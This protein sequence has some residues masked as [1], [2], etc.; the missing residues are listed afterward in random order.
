MGLIQNMPEDIPTTNAL[1]YIEDPEELNE[2]GLSIDRYLAFGTTPNAIPHPPKDG[3]IVTYQVK[4]ECVGQ[5][6]KRRAD[7]EVRYRSDLTI[8]SVARVG[9]EL[10][11]DYTPEPTAAQKR[12]VEKARAA[13]EQAERDEAERAE[14]EHNEP[15]MF[16]EDGDPIAIDAHGGPPEDGDVVDC[17]VVEDD[18][19]QGD[20]GDNVVQFSDKSKT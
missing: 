15:P 5:A 7:G 8:L 1:D 4:V 20:N 10:P 2:Y 16:D 3:E 12:A 19:D 6:H 13:A 11:A 18:E 14:R 17:E 9:E